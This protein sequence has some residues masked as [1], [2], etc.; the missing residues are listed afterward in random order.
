MQ[1]FLHLLRMNIITSYPSFALT[2]CGLVFSNYYIRKN[3]ID[4]NQFAFS[5]RLC[6]K[7]SEWWRI[8][9]SSFCHNS[10]I[11]LV[12]DILTLWDLRG[13]ETSA[14]SLFF[15]RY[16][17]L[18]IVTQKFFLAVAIQSIISYWPHYA[19]ILENM[20]MLGTSGLVF[21]WLGYYAVAITS[22]KSIVHI[23]GIL[24]MS[25]IYV[26]TMMTMIYQVAMPR[27]TNNVGCLAGLLC[28]M[29]LGLGLLQILPNMYWTA[30]FLVNL[31]ILILK[32][33]YDSTQ[34]TRTLDDNS[35]GLS[36]PDL[37][38]YLLHQQ[39]GGAPLLLDELDH[40]IESQQQQHNNEQQQ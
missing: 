7:R 22:D 37:H 1:S 30:C 39:G 24:P 15:L 31:S 34:M 33:I 23:F 2:I 35:F 9:S 28:G 12:L 36:I 29:C 3:E 13:I 6:V 19:S 17:M 14:G 5:Y 20:N 18:L 11:H 40:D 8:L 26:P 16:S 10:L 25:V 32:S 4:G 21:A 27:S 38:P